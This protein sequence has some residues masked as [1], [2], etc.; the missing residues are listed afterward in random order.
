VVQMIKDDSFYIQK[1]LDEAA[2]AFA[3]DEVPIGAIV[4][5]AQGAIIGQAYNQTV[6]ENSPLAHAEILAIKQAAEALGDWRLDDCTLYVTLEPCTLCMQLIIMSRIK[7]LVY[8][9]SSPLYGF[10]SDKFCVF[11]VSKMKLMIQ[12]GIEEEAAQQLL[13]RFFNKKRS[14]NGTQKIEQ[15]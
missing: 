5:D 4:V 15:G 13:K 6:K 10:S 2:Q 8:G 7:R 14:C 1:A 9:A 3:V 11:D 12:K